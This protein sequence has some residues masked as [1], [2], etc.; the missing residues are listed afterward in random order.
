MASYSLEE[1]RRHN[2]S[3]SLWVARS[4]NVYDVTAF[5]DRHPGGIELLLGK[6][7]EDV[8]GVMETSPHIHSPAAF[9][10]LN[11]YL[12]GKLDCHRRAV[13][14]ETTGLVSCLSSKSFLPK[15]QL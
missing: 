11:K 5:A 12:I 1:L 6:G 3:D 15:T 8:T 2:H 14:D 10:I 9:Q 7:G 13:S 4:G